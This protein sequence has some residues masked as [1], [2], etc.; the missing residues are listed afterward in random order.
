MYSEKPKFKLNGTH[1]SPKNT[2]FDILGFHKKRTF[3]E[4]GEL[5]TVEYY[6]TYDGITYSDLILKEERAYTRNEVTNLVAYRDLTITFYLTDDSIGYVKHSKKYYTLIEAYSE[7]KIRRQNLVNFA[8]IDYPTGLFFKVG[9]DNALDFLNDVNTQ[10][11]VY[12]GGNVTTLLDAI[13]DSTKPYMTQQIK[14]DLIAILD[15]GA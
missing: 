4:K 1:N 5:T 13:Q 12:I 15:D 2:N 11:G 6:R 8:S 10:I 7:G 14:D 9:K 3:N